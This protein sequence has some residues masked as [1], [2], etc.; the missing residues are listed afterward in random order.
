MPMAI[1]GIGATIYGSQRATSMSD[2]IQWVSK[3]VLSPAAPALPRNML[4]V[5]VLGPHP[6]PTDSKTG[7]AAQV[8][9]WGWGRSPE[10]HRWF[11]YALK[12]KNHEPNKSGSPPPFSRDPFPIAYGPPAVA[13]QLISLEVDKRLLTGTFLGLDAWHTACNFH[14]RNMRKTPVSF[15]PDEKIVAETA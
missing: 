13:T 4:E 3:V 5:T 8:M 11:W 12:F 10:P 9:G 14:N 6:I 15:G 2:L 1:P 7:V